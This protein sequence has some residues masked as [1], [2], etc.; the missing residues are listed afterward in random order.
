MVGRTNLGGLDGPVANLP[1]HR[2]ARRAHLVHADRGVKHE[3]VRRA[4]SGER[5][6]HE[7]S[8]TPI[9]NADHLS[10]APAGLASG[11]IRFM[12]VGTPSSFRTGA[13]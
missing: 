5:M 9:R 13:T 3:R 2:L 12:I 7:W 11:P 10:R 6:S 4:E 1:H 8:T